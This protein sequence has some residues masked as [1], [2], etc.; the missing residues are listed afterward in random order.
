MWNLYDIPEEI[1]MDE[2]IQGK[3]EE[4]TVGFGDEMSYYVSEGAEWN[5]SMRAADW[6]GRHGDYQVSTEDPIGELD[7][8][9][10]YERQR[11]TKIS[12][13]EW[14]E[15]TTG[16]EIQGLYKPGM[17]K[18]DAE[19]LIRKDKEREV[20]DFI[21][22]NRDGGWR[23]MAG[24][25]LA[26]GTQAIDPSVWVPI[27]GHGTKVNAIGRAF[28]LSRLVKSYPVIGGF[29]VNA[30]D[31]AVGTA[32][33]DMAIIPWMHSEGN[34]TPWSAMAWDV[35]FSMGAA[36][37]LTSAGHGLN[38]FTRY[39]DELDTPGTAHKKA[40]DDYIV[41]TFGDKATPEQI[42]TV[43]REYEAWLKQKADDPT[44]PEFVAK[45][46][47]L[48]A[49]ITEKM[50]FTDDG[51]ERLVEAEHIE[52]ANSD[53][54]ELLARKEAGELDADTAR[55]ATELEAERT[56]I[57]SDE[58]VLQELVDRCI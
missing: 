24:M 5:I 7:F 16:R 37:L 51:L 8:A 58:E 14:N 19:Y 30:A 45:E 1:S 26:L 50:D 46:E 56:K 22:Q 43:T 9:D 17:N 20:R 31:A 36:G 53:L 57:E 29:V 38:R 40:L 4:A 10:E 52:R 6:L 21:Y 33:A 32:L 47:T 48:Q 18:L 13:E 34:D 23:T 11:R 41:E 2:Y 35:M 55:R 42:R 25:G 15:L 39:V 12:K 27:F 54:D 3:K 28:G 49:E 44:P